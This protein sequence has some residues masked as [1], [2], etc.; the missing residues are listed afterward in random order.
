MLIRE[1]ICY[2]DF[3]FNYKLI[4]DVDPGPGECAVPF[5]DPR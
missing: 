5:D 2:Y 1:D 3:T 4:Q